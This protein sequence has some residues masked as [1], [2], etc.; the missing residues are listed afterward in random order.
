MRREVT[1]MGRGQ[2]FVAGLAAATALISLSMFSMPSL[3]QTAATTTTASAAT[4][5]G[6]NCT[7]AAVPTPDPSNHQMDPFLGQL[8]PPSLPA[9]LLP[10][11]DATRNSI[12]GV[13]LP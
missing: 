1:I 7:S 11:N 10:I 5:G 4:A 3:S 8:V 12:F 13:G 9:G 6:L 2:S